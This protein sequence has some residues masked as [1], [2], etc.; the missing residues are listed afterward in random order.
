MG[1]IHTRASKK[2]DKA[3]AKLL[4]AELHE[5][6]NEAATDLPWWRQR[7]VGAAITTAMQDRKKAS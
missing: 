5:K 3:E 4:K 6:E 7:T 2:R 1:L